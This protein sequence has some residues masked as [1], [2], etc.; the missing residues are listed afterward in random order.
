M[1]RQ[2]VVDIAMGIMV[3]CV[4]RIP[5]KRR[6][7]DRFEAYGGGDANTLVVDLSNMQQMTWNTTTW[8]ATIGAGSLLGNITDWMTDTENRA[9]AHGI[10]PQV[11][12]EYCTCLLLH[13]HFNN[14]LVGGHATIGGLG[15]ASRMWGAALDH[16]VGATV[17]VA[18]GSIVRVTATENSDL[19]WA[20]KGAAAGFGVVTDF[21][22]ITHVPP[23]QS[24]AY[25]YTFSGRPFLT[26]GQRLKSWMK[27]IADPNL[28]RLLASEVY[29]T[30]FG[31]VIEGMFYGTQDEFDALNLTAVFPD[32]SSSSTLVF[33]N[34]A[35][36]IGHWFEDTALQ[37]GGGLP[38]WFFAKS[39]VFTPN[40]ILS[41][42][43]VD[44]ML[45]YLDDTDPGAILWFGIFDLSGGAVMDVAQDATAF[46]HR[47]ALFYFQPYIVNIGTVTQT[48]KDFL[49]G[50]ITNLETSSPGTKNNGAYAGYVDPTLGQAG[51]EAYWST[52]LPRLEQIKAA[53]DPTDMFHNPQSVRLPG[54]S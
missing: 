44:S 30:T 53:W 37:V 54:Q 39:L 12:S 1:Y 52:N 16:I 40:D 49:D 50:W 3:C 26:Y 35:G 27:M 24:I 22:I 7:A 13:H 41:D 45:Q 9:F 2:E 36:S 34:W 14:L 21:D 20:I 33:N 4:Q 23:S 8:V 19:F 25:S 29:F 48:N 6:G 42:D 38:T 32:A 10:C 11:G 18:N 51:Q 31:M 17:V 46:S 5:D 28:S 15:P 47:D 43:G